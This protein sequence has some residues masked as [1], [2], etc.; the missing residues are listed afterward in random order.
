[1]ENCCDVVIVLVIGIGV[2]I[3][4]NSVSKQNDIK[5]S[6]QLEQIE[7]KVR[8]SIQSGDKEKALDLV[9][10]LIHPSHKDME[11]QKFDTWH[12]YPKYD[13][14]WAQKREKYKEQILKLGGTPK[15]VSKQETQQVQDTQPE[16]TTEQTPT[17]NETSDFSSNW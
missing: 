17:K 12:G 11:T 4:F 3:Y 8:L 10:Q 6:Q 14:Y 16:Q 9:N 15:I 1:M 5:I 7:D 2:F 13:E